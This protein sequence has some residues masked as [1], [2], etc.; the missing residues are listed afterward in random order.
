MV[1]SAVPQRLVHLTDPSTTQLSSV[2]MSE[3]NMV[4][5]A[6]VFVRNDLYFLLT[7]AQSKGGCED[8]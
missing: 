6:L 8:G 2:S 4:T 5:S 7:G 1:S 3:D